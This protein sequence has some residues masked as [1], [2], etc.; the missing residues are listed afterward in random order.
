MSMYINDM[1]DLA[2]EAQT[3]AISR[4]ELKGWDPDLV[5]TTVDYITGALEGIA[6]GVRSI[7]EAFALLE[8]GDLP[9]LAKERIKIEERLL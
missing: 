7:E 3:R 4:E 9:R 6:S 5:M 2:K 1:N 8:S